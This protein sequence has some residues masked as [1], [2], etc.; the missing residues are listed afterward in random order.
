MAWPDLNDGRLHGS[1]GG[2]GTEVVG[3]GCHLG[4]VLAGMCGVKDPEI[5]AAVERANRFA[6]FYV[7]KGAIP[8]G[9][10]RPGWDVH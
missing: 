5:E 3:V 10:H 1:L 4:L 9:D 6:R 8:Y 2:Y 7:S